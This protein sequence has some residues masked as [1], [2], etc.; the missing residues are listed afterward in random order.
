MGRISMIVNG[1][2]QRSRAKNYV[3]AFISKCPTE[4]ER[5]TAHR[6][7]LRTTSP[8]I[9]GAAAVSPSPSSSPHLQRSSSTS[10]GLVIKTAPG[11]WTLRRTPIL[12]SFSNGMD[13]S[14]IDFVYT[15]RHEEE[16]QPSGGSDPR[17]TP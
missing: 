10:P 12:I 14:G 9:R 3:H 17:D 15:L 2:H 13:A 1:I 4:N 11:N 6:H 16:G 5:Q 8:P 7:L